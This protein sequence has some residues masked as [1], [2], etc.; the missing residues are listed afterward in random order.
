MC[1]FS[2]LKDKRVG[3]LTEFEDLSLQA[4]ASVPEDVL[5]TGFD[6]VRVVRASVLEARMEQTQ[7]S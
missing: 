5:E 6:E 4:K 3:W 7:L 1:P 2:F